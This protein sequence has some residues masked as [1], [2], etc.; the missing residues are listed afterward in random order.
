M[1]ED[2]ETQK[3]FRSRKEEKAVEWSNSPWVGNERAIGPP[4]RKVWRGIH[5]CHRTRRLRSRTK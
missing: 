2:V 3:V 5:S 4:S 1:R